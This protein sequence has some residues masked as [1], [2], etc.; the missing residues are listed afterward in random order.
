MNQRFDSSGELKALHA[1][2]FEKSSSRSR[3]FLAVDRLQVSKQE[4]ILM[5][6]FCG[7]SSESLQKFR[8]SESGVM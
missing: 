3:R 5:G 7:K 4:A 2:L 1:T 6:T 8:P